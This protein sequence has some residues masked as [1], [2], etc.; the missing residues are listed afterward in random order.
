MFNGIMASVG[1]LKCGEF[2]FWKQWKWA[3]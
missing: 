2:S 3:S 1:I